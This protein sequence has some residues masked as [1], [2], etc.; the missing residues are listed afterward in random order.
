MAASR[1]PL[2][3]LAY[4]VGMYSFRSFAEGKPSWIL[5]YSWE[6]QRNVSPREAMENLAMA[7]IMSGCNFWDARGHVMSGS[8]NIET[9]KLI[10]RWIRDHQNTF[11]SPRVPVNPIGV[12][13]SPETRDQFPNEFI[14]SLSRYDDAASNVAPGVS[15]C[16]TQKSP[17]FRR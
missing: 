14:R 5:N 6:G 17:Q 4:M 15:G 1:T 3:W 2:D 8:N 7:E 13:F 16:D 11:Y 9:R 10:F 12:Y